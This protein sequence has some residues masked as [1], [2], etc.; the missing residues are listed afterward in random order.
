MKKQALLVSS[1]FL[2]SIFVF[3]DGEDFSG[4]D[5][6]GESFNSQS[7]VGAKFVES[8]LNNATFKNAN[9]ESADFTRANMSGTNLTWA[10]LSGTNFT[11]ANIQNANFGSASELTSTQLYSTASY[12]N[13]NLTGVQISTSDLSGWDFSNQNL[14]NAVLLGSNLANANF[15]N[16]VITGA[17]F[18]RTTS[19][20]FTKEQLY[21]TLSYKNKDL[22]GINLASTV[23]TPNDLSGW[24]FSGQNLTN[25]NFSNSILTNANFTDAVIAGA[26][27]EASTIVGLTKELIYSTLSYKNKNLQGV[28]FGDTNYD[29]NNV[30]TDWDFSGQDLSS[31]RFRYV[32]LINSDFTGAN[33][34]Y[35]SFYS[36]I[37][38][39]GSFRGANLTGVSFQKATLSNMDFRKALQ[40]NA[41]F[42]GSIQKNIIG[43][44]GIIGSMNLSSEGNRLDIVKYTP[45]SAQLRSHQTISNK[46]TLALHAGAV[47]NVT[48]TAILAL[49]TNGIIEMEFTETDSPILN[50]T[51]GSGFRMN[52][53][54]FNIKLVGDF[55]D[56]DVF[57]ILTWNDGATITGL[58]TLLVN[59]NV[60]V[61]LN[62]RQLDSWDMKVSNNALTLT[63][64]PEPSFYAF[65]FGAMCLAFVV[66]RRRLKN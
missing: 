48:A 3:A 2:F 40:T 43:N 31:A 46:G 42:S 34:S 22:S 36:S 30:L 66:M 21:S 63:S 17:S 50:I 23:L 33:L 19:R 65:G 57:A 8:V 18:Y 54:V 61:S 9:L 20:G 26:S 64:I 11:D 53:G 1:L 14:T 60:F 5:L 59:G 29:F 7:L 28:K 62:G 27:F 6:S 41:D 45:L 38:S 52:G 51:S 35:A 4:Q 56:S 58:D 39:D 49:G 13:R 25:A 15:T 10:T 37:Q 16:A 47:L 12:K 24:D 32:S 55:D 44:D